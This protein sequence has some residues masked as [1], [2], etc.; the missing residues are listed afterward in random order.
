MS[1]KTIAKSLSIK[2]N[3]L[4]NA[5]GSIINLG[6]QWLVSILLVRFSTGFDD[7]GLYSIAMAVFAI[8]APIGQ[9]R[10]YTV[11]VSDV[12]HE[13]S[14]GEYLSFRFVTQFTALL[15]CVIYSYFTS[16][17]EAL[18]VTLAYFAFR[19]VALTIDVFHACD[20]I[21]HRMDLIGKSL[22]MQGI[23]SIIV[24]IIV[25]TSTH[26]LALT[27]LLMAGAVALI[28]MV[29]DYPRVISFEIV[30]LGISSSK[31]RQLFTSCL[32]IVL[33]AVAA[34]ASYSIPRQFLASLYG[35]SM[36]GIYASVAMPVAIIQMGA[37][38]IYNPLLSYFAE[39][40]T[41]NDRSV[42]NRL[43]KQCLLYMTILFVLAV[44]CVA[45]F[46]EFAL[47]LLY[48]E[49]IR[50]YANLLYPLIV[51]A[52]ITGLMWFLNDLL[53]TIRDFKGCFL[54]SIALLLSSLVCLPL[55][56]HF[57]MNGVT[58]VCIV[59][60]LIGIFTMSMFLKKD[61]HSQF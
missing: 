57:D 10:M 32:P 24:F 22:A 28:G 49:K 60:A 39:A 52:L 21:H 7:A 16:S 51:L 40:Y 19:A 44:V 9:Y 50:C 55:I 12:T 53:I 48:G 14:L 43:I 61:L 42:F 2:Q 37:S 38:Y 26:N 59:S 4:W 46:G 45:V 58:L 8:F 29:Y 56:I 6:C 23:I 17:L 27:L 47:V 3:M 34:S 18:F 30:S 54:G 20:Q 31:I 13:N 1:G 15:L 33:A 5:F 11:Q 35:E 41:Y 25:Y 36:L